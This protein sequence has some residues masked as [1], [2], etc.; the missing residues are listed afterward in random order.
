MRTHCTE[1]W[2]GAIGSSKTDLHCNW[3]FHSV[4]WNLESPDKSGM[5]TL[6]M[7][8]NDLP[9][10]LTIFRT[11]VQSIDE[12]GKNLFFAKTSRLIV[13]SFKAHQPWELQTG[14]S[15]HK[16]VPSECRWVQRES[17]NGQSKIMVF[18]FEV[19]HRNYTW[20]SHVLPAQSEIW[21]NSKDFHF[22]FFFELSGRCW[23][24]LIT[25]A[26]CMAT[27]TE[28]WLEQDDHHFQPCAQRCPCLCCPQDGEHFQLATPNDKP[29]VRVLFASR[30]KPLFADEDQNGLKISPVQLW[31][32]RDKSLG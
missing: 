6:M 29:K 19:Q 18:K 5:L 10:D 4:I 21:T 3:V 32:C 9:G 26:K 12:L 11:C 16:S 23:G 14:P 15:V 1:F 24:Y 22:F 17:N 25:T 27:G 31:T 30:E 8:S 20:T 2:W 7:E 28:S 13:A